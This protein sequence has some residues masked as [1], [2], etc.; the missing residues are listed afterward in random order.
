[1][2]RGVVMSGWLV[3]LRVADTLRRRLSLRGYEFLAGNVAPDSSNYVSDGFDPPTEITHFT[4]TDKSACD[5]NAFAARYIET[6]ADERIRLFY[7][8]YFCHL[9]TDVMWSLKIC[10]PCEERFAEQFRQDEKAFYKTVKRDWHA[11]DFDFLEANPHYPPLEQ[12]K[13]GKRLPS[14]LLDYFADGM[15]ERKIRF[16]TRYYSARRD[17]ESDYIYLTHAMA[18][19][20]VRE[21]AAEIERELL[22]RGYAQRRNSG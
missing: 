2:D 9:M 11:V 12:L 4:R 20:F 21:A 19:N 15:I 18:D 5:Y 10:K 6:A 7:I 3:H 16:I 14:G 22:E 8:G 13:C 17:Y 1:M